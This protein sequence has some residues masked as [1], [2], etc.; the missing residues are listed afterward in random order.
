ALAP[1]RILEV[2]STPI[3]DQYAGLGIDRPQR[4]GDGAYRIVDPGQ[5]G[6]TVQR[7]GAQLGYTSANAWWGPGVHNSLIMTNNAAGVPRT[8]VG[9]REP[10]SIG[11]GK[12]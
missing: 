5:S 11:I 3:A 10:V 7:W 9:T 4:F 2:N 1:H 12:L 6:I 8:F